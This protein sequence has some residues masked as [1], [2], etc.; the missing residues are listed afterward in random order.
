MR[1]SRLFASIIFLAIEFLWAIGLASILTPIASAEIK[2]KVVDP[3]DAAVARAEVQ[4]LKL[5]K[6]APAAIQSTSAEGLAIFREA[7]S[8]SY[9]VQ[10]LAPGFAA[11]M[12]TLDAS[13]TTE[14]TTIKLRVA[15]AAETVVVTATRTPVPSQAAGAQVDTLRA[16]SWK[17]CSR[18]P[19]TTPCA[20]CRARS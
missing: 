9:R 14:V 16:S 20:S 15:T 11:E 2:I 4:L 13:P 1:C 5:G 10:V 17:Q 3:Q 8:S 7:P 19:R 18:L 12:V 6:P